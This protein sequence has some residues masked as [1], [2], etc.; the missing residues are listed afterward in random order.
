MK[1]QKMC[2]IVLCNV[3]VTGRTESSVYVGVRS[4][5]HAAESLADVSAYRR[6][7]PLRVQSARSVQ[8]IPGMARDNFIIFII[9]KQLSDVPSVL[10]RWWLGS[11]KGIRPV[12]TE[13]WGAGI[14]I[15]LE[16]GA[17]L[18][19]AQLMPLPLTVSLLQ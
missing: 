2:L 1:M 11:R 9:W 18:H 17:E 10:W 15:C 7:V 3:L 8:Y 12:K 6:Q 5:V 13:W 14:V 4:T 16:Q 19:M